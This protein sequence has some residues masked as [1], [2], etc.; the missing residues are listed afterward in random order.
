MKLD[1]TF[2]AVLQQGK[3]KGSWIRII[4]PGS[5]DFFGTRGVVKVRGT[6]DGQPFEG[7]FIPMGDG[8]HMLPVNALAR[9]ALGKEIG[10]TLTI[11]LVERL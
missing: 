1:K 6:L 4:M 11:H 8:T 2:T 3:Q 10:D 7:S 5:A 9:K